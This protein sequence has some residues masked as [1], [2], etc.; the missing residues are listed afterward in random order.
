ME[1][2]I[3]QSNSM[4][5]TFFELKTWKTFFFFSSV[6][7]QIFSR[8]EPDQDFRIY[9]MSSEK[10]KGHVPPPHMDRRNPGE[11]LGVQHSPESKS[12]EGCSGPRRD[13]H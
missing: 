5:S 4:G 1:H 7:G 10:N 13:S 8:E 6:G 9:E 11:G 3:G 2:G 12:R